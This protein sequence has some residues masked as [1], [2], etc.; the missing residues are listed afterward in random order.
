M[1][2]KLPM[3]DLHLMSLPTGQAPRPSQSWKWQGCDVPCVVFDGTLTPLDFALS[4]SFDHLREALES[5]SRIYFELDGSFL[6]AGDLNGQAWRIDGMVYDDGER[7]LW[8]EVKGCLPL[9][10]WKQLLQ[11]VGGTQEL[12][13]M[14]LPDRYLVE[15][16][17]LEPLWDA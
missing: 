5:Q 10:Q 6:W 4:Q 11:I 13:A 8:C 16:R 15:T 14:V 1:T 17:N 3:L 9:S 12:L 7:V 2:S